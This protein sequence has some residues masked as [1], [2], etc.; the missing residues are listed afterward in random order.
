[1]NG[2]QIFVLLYFV[3]TIVAIYRAMPNKGST[4]V[5]NI[6]LGWTI[7]GWIVALAMACGKKDSALTF[8]SN[9]NFPPPARPTPP[10]QGA[11]TR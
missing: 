5:V 1:M 6:F 9:P 11:P 3:P 4:I 2:F 8:I 7:I 10:P